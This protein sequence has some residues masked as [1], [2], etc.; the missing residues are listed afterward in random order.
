MRREFTLIAMAF[1]AAPSFLA[2]QSLEYRNSK[3]LDTSIG[4]MS[5][6]TWVDGNTWYAIADKQNLLAELNISINPADGSMSSASI[7]STSTIGGVSGDYEGIAYSASRNSFF[8]SNEATNAVHE[9]NRTDLSQVFSYPSPTSFNN[10]RGNLNLESLSMNRQGTLLYTANEEALSIDGSRATPDSPTNVRIVQYSITGNTVGAGLSELYQFVYQVDPIVQDDASGTTH[11]GQSGLSDMLVLPDGKLLMLEREVYYTR[12]FSIQDI[13]HFRTRIYLVDPANAT[14]L[15]NPAA[16]ILDSSNTLSA[17]PISKT[18][19]FEGTSSG[20]LGIDGFVNMEGLATGPATENGW[21]ILGI[22]DNQA[23]G[24]I[25]TTVYAF[26]YLP[27][28][29][30]PATS[31]LLFLPTS[32]LMLSRRNSIT[33][34][35]SSAIRESAS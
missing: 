2:A 29:P 18:L 4:E 33:H 20:L 34:H 32:W 17:T 8:L 24:L 21:S 19:L 15:A 7:A 11:D 25:S 28:I 13:P 35:R 16:S 1:A 26:E 31:L 3:S 12:L 10:A 9:V 27:A 6:I 23:N 22:N 14:P 30:E 5:G